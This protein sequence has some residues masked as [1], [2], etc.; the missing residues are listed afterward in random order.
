MRVRSTARAIKP[1][2]T[3]V[4][5]VDTVTASWYQAAVMSNAECPECAGTI[6]FTEKPVLHELVRCAE[7]NAE[8]EIVRLE[9][10]T[11]ELAPTEQEDW[12]E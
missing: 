11:L 9:P 6:A 5:S 10:V 7:C 3:Y 8:L 1:V 2:T 12:G 4:V